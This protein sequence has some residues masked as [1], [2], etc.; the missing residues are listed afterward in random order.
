[1]MSAAAAPA[2]KISMVPMSQK[3]NG[4]RA[5]CKIKKRTLSALGVTASLLRP[6]LLFP[7]R[8]ALR[9]RAH[10]QATKFRRN[11]SCAQRGRPG[12][13]ARDICRRRATAHL[14]ECPG[15]T[16]RYMGGAR[17]VQLPGKSVQVGIGLW[18]LAGLKRT[19][20]VSLSSALLRSFGSRTAPRRRAP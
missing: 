2:A 15:L 14:P 13:L 20:T 9:S 6:I 3:Q 19:R 8:S 7:A 16:Q 4:K 5:I 10:S 17:A 1:M 18:F 11:P 12:C